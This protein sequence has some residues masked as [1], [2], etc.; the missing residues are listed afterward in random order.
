MT[1]L[2]AAILAFSLTVCLT[3]IVKRLAIKFNIV[4]VP[5]SARKIHKVSTPLLGGVAIFIAYFLVIL[6]FREQILIGNLSY[7]PWLGFFI[8]ALIL[9][10]GGVLDD[11]YN[12][13]PQQQII[14]PLLAIAALIIG[15]VSIGEI[16]NPFGGY[17]ILDNWAII[18]PLL[19]SLWLLGMMYTTKLLDGVDGLVSGISA[20]GG[21]IIFLFTLT[22]RYYQPDIALASIVLVAVCLGFLIFNFN[23]AKIFLGE[24]G[25]LLLGYI[26]GVLA[27][28]SGGKI[29]IA[30]LV[31]GI[32]I[33]DVAWTIFRRLLAGQ[34]P[35]RMADKK[36][37]HHRLLALGLSQ[38]QT[39]LVF[40]SLA[41]VFGLSGL[42]LQSRGKLFALIILLGIMLALV[43]IISYFKIKKPKLLLH[44]CCAPCSAYI[45][46]ELLSPNYDL[47]LYF[48]NSNLCD[49]SEYEKRL[50]CVKDLADRYK[51]PLII[52]PYNQSAWEKLTEG[53]EHEPET[54]K[55]CEVCILDRLQKTINLANKNKFSYF[56]T[57]L[58]VSPYKNS[59]FIK[60][61]CLN[62]AKSSPVKFLEMDF[63][64][65]DGYAKSQALAKE[66]GFYR[67]KFCGC[68]YSIKQ[69][70]KT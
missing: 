40:Y 30:L 64:A 43:I 49:V 63:Q 35:L 53:L 54:G 10:I 9:V 60:R 62:L 41:L 18:S 23:P 51:W 3:L 16:S 32:P 15:G 52:E 20:I 26:L 68:K 8:G 65:D 57:S 69:K 70:N 25:S 38:K 47:T 46:R 17:F 37:L 42:F 66:L 48:Y 33:L 13:K 56:S 39:V 24:S 1:Y 22:T 44:V 58:L 61:T 12:L 4:D 21:L 36:H 2:L 59:E 67:Q 50:A 28:I 34:N 6:L 29:A 5:D 45:S 31:M 27:I 55:R 7:K 19:I 11:K 14:F